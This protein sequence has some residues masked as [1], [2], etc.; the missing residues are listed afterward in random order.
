MRLNFYRGLQWCGLINTETKRNEK[1]G[2]YALIMSRTCF[3]V[4]PDSADSEIEIWNLSDCSWT[5]THN[6]LFVN[7]HSQLKNTEIIITWSYIYNK[8]RIKRIIIKLHHRRHYSFRQNLKF[9][10]TEFILSR[11]SSIFVLGAS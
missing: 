5:R 4:N 8:I 1:H 10:K 9:I 7:E 11:F 2:L 6:H 3:R